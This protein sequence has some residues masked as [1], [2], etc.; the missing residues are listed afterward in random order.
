[1]QIKTSK[2]KQLI[3]ILLPSR[4][5]LNMIPAK[6]LNRV[7]SNIKYRLG[8][9]YVRMGLTPS[10]KYE[11]VEI[12]PTPLPQ[13]PYVINELPLMTNFNILARFLKW[14]Y[15]FYL[16]EC[17]YD[18]VL[19]ILNILMFK[20]KQGND[21]QTNLFYQASIPAD[22]ANELLRRPLA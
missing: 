9:Y 18:I 14:H 20:S 13:D 5:K 11:H 2:K 22:W 17:L 3:L 6:P 19:K 10:L 15:K 12:F 21:K 7:I 4:H 8:K 16:K 1:M